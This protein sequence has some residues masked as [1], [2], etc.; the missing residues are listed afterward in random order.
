MPAAEHAV[1]RV[2]REVEGT[3]AEMPAE[4]AET[5]HPAGSADE[6]AARRS[7]RTTA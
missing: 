3:L 2:V 6:L 4:R 5:D 1:G 7:R